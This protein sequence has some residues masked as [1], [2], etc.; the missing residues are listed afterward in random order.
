MGASDQP[1][2]AYGRIAAESLVLRR[3][4]LD[5]MRAVAATDAAGFRAATGER[6]ALGD[7][8]ERLE[9]QGAPTL[10]GDAEGRERLATLAMADAM[11]RGSQRLLWIGARPRAVDRLCERCGWRLVEVRNERG[12]YAGAG[13]FWVADLETAPP[14][15]GGA[16]P[17]DRVVHVGAIDEAPWQG[18]TIALGERGDVVAPAFDRPPPAEHRVPRSAAAEAVDSALE[19]SL[20]SLEPAL[21]PL[22]RRAASGTNADRRAVLG[23]LTTRLG[24]MVRAARAER[25]DDG[26]ETAR[27]LASDHDG[28]DAELL[29]DALAER[30][31]SAPSV[32]ALEAERETLDALDAALAAKPD[33]ALERLVEEA[34]SAEGA[35]LVLPGRASREALAERLGHGAADGSVD[36]R[37]E[38][39]RRGAVAIV[40][41]AEHRDARLDRVAYEGLRVIAMDSVPIRAADAIVGE[42]EPTKNAPR[43]TTER[44]PDEH[45]ARWSGWREVLGLTTAAAHP[46]ARETITAALAFGAEPWTLARLRREEGE[47]LLIIGG[48]CALGPAFDTR[49]EAAFHADLRLLA[50]AR[51]R[52]ERALESARERWRSAEAD[53]AARHGAAESAV[54]DA[55][56]RQARSLGDD[57]RGEAT[58]A[59]ADAEEALEALRA[60]KRTLAEHHDTERRRALDRFAAAPTIDPMNDDA[61]PPTSHPSAR[62]SR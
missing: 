17:F 36:A 21:G 25:T 20:L 23:R 62:L 14:G 49:T 60:E 9:D 39:A 61:A 57:A 35:V 56:R 31:T 43:P 13:L 33:P 54:E 29:R 46:E 3:S 48:T 18:P 32:A 34:G 42:G 37:L 16:D 8:L 11:V 19:G 4:A 40:G 59:I 27:Q 7:L 26:T 51:R 44:E 38:A 53:R 15:L 41:V 55:R 22:A 50:V 47:A 5:P 58:R 45:E 12:A 10:G 1:T 24:R 30:A 6:N 52:L 28:V 2:K